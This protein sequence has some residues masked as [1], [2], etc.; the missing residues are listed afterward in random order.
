MTLRKRRIILLISCLV[1]LGAAPL[2]LLYTA[3]YKITSN[4]LISRT[5]GLYVSSPLSG[6]EIFVKN[7]KEKET[8]IL[9][10]GLFLQNLS[11]GNYPIIVAKEGFW[12]WQKTLNIKEGLVAEARA[13]LIP[14]NPKG[15]VL[16]KGRFENFWASSY[17]KVLLLEENKSSGWRITFYLPDTDT[18]LTNDSL[19][20]AK[21]LSFK[22]S[23]SKIFWE[24]KAVLLMEEKEI[25]R[26]TFNF[27]NQTVSASLLEIDD[28]SVNPI[29]EKFSN[30]VNNKYEKIS[31][32]KKERI[33]Q[34]N[35]TNEIWLEWL[36]DKDF[37]PYYL[38]DTKPCPTTYLIA[39]FRSPIKNVDF[40]PGRRD[41]LATAV[42][43]SVFALETDKRGGQL[44]QPIYKG[45]DPTFAVFSS[46]KI[47]YVLDNGALLAVNLES[48]I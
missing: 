30:G 5:G 4:F 47:I 22:N 29:R 40:F 36:G 37:I 34:N 33:W 23:I 21:L 32:R 9:Q 27:D 24:D 1:F 43:N 16:L 41:L 17:D 3:G 8:N 42:Q 6:S 7:K 20:T 15:R 13:F 19:K 14:M 2:L 10:S 18:F 48:N 31:E 46:E 26:V 45:K 12:P 28:I 44:M 35:Q 39:S 25:I 38:C 11:P